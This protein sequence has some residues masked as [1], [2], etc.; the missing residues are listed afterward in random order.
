MHNVIILSFFLG[1]A[2]AMDAFS[3]SMADG[4]FVG[5][6]H[7]TYRFSIPICFSF[8][9]MLMPLTGYILVSLATAAFN[10]I[11]KYIPYVGSILLLFIGAKMIIESIKGKSEDKVKLSV[12][13]ILVQAIATSIDALSVGLTMVHYNIAEIF[14]S[15]LII[16]IITFILCLTGI[17]IGRGAKKF[18]GN[19]AE[20]LGG[21]ILIIIAIKLLI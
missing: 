12:R 17:Y 2:L 11:Y 3:V 4:V 19:K 10:S 7:K 16:G 18:I 6:N 1:V 9:Q 20:I 8:F 15:I 14:I 21:I 5:N 13:I